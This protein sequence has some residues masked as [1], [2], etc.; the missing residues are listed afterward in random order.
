MFWHRLLNRHKWGTESVIVVPGLKNP[1]FTATNITAEEAKEITREL[2]T[3]F[4]TIYQECKI[5]GDRRKIQE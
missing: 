1:K 3:G 2:R 5:C 4:R